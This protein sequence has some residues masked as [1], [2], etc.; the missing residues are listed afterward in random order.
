[1][2]T[3]SDK[4]S[5][6]ND[7]VIAKLSIGFH[8]QFLIIIMWVAR[9]KKKAQT[10]LY[11]F[12]WQSILKSTF[13]RA[14]KCAASR[15]FSRSLHRAF[16]E[17]NA[18]LIE[19]HSIKQKRTVISKNCWQNIQSSRTFSRAFGKTYNA[20]CQMLCWQNVEQSTVNHTDGVKFFPYSICI[21]LL[22]T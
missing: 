15:T 7:T 3:G 1:M 22:Q 9:S 14:L 11:S 8:F 21:C 12:S 20:H 5:C 2:D 19:Q 6:F 10:V 4:R 18:L 13:R 16:G 17:N